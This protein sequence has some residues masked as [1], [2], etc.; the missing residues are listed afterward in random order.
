MHVFFSLRPSVSGCCVSPP[1]TQLLQE[2]G[3]PCHGGYARVEYAVDS[4]V[5]DVRDVCCAAGT[6][7]V[8][9]NVEPAMA[10]WLFDRVKAAVPDRCGKTTTPHNAVGQHA[11]RGCS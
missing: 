1:T 2:A 3:Q 4:G 11:R 9:M 8:S 7:A 6:R 10:G 5:E